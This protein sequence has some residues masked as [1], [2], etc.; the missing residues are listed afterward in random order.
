V[1]ITPSHRP[2]TVA[3]ARGP[4]G[5]AVC[6]DGGEQFPVGGG[7]RLL[8]A[9]CLD[10]PGEDLEPLAGCVQRPPL[11]SARGRAGDQGEGDV[12]AMAGDRAG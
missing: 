10:G 1:A 9:G 12:G 11:L 4:G 8:L 6:G 2:G 7:D 5:Q 3:A